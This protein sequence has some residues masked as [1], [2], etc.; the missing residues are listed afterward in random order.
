M[1]IIIIGAG[2]VGFQIAQKLSS[3]DKEVVVIDNNAEVLERVSQSIDVQTVH[4]SGSSPKILEK[5]GIK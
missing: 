1:R 4:G 2:Q 3:E 5:A